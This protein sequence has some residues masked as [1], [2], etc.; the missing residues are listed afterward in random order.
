MARAFLVVL[1]SVGIFRPMRDL[2]SVLHQ[3]MVGMSAAQGIYRILDEQP[4]VADVPPA[5]LLS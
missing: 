4:M 3:G 5:P 2:R 1:D